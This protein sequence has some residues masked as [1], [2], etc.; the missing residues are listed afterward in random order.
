MICT[1][2]KKWLR[3]Y[4]CAAGKSDCRLKTKC[5]GTYYCY[6][7]CMRGK[8]SKILKNYIMLIWQQYKKTVPYYMLLIIQLY[9]FVQ[10]TNIWIDRCRVKIKIMFIIC[11]YRILKIQDVFVYCNEIDDDKFIQLQHRYLNNNNIYVHLPLF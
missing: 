9:L 1:L 8:S 5:V 10:N 6:Q 7:V 4:Y 2:S 3:Q 11:N